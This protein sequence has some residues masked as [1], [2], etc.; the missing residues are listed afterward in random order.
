MRKIYFFATSILFVIG[1]ASCAKEP[2]DPYFDRA[3][4]ASKEAHQQ[5]ERD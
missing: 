2:Q 1:L 3:K 5:L 4:Q